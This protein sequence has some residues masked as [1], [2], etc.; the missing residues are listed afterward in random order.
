MKVDTRSQ[1][2]PNHTDMN[3]C[4]NIKY[5]ESGLTKIRCVS[6][7]HLKKGMY[8]HVTLKGLL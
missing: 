6:D 7:N 4:M 5:Q 3:V 1:H 2:P 8:K